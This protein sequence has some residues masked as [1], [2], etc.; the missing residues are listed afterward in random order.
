MTQS[1]Y[2]YSSEKKRFFENAEKPLVPLLIFFEE[3]DE[4]K[5]PSGMVEIFTPSANATIDAPTYSI[6]AAGT[7]VDGKREGVWTDIADD[8]S[9]YTMAEYKN[10]KIIDKAEEFYTCWPFEQNHLIK[11]ITLYNEKGE[12][13]GA[14]KEFYDNGELKEHTT[15]RNGVE[16]GMSFHYKSNGRLSSLVLYAHGEVNGSATSSLNSS[17][18]NM[19]FID[20]ARSLLKLSSRDA[21]QINEDQLDILEVR[22]PQYFP[23]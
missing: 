17:L 13:D 22:Y 21:E 1:L 10:D 14:Y 4:D 19:K 8:E 3:L 20:N 2:L 15:F 18:N 16:D 11:S 7:L 9:S 5:N 12:K 23:G 6:K